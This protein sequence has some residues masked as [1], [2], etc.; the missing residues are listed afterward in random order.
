MVLVVKSFQ[1]YIGHGKTQCVK[2]MSWMKK[3]KRCARRWF[4]R[5]EH[6]TIRAFGPEQKT[7][8]TE[9]YESK[10]N[11]LRRKYKQLKSIHRA[12]LE[13]QLKKSQTEIMKLKAR[14]AELE[15]NVEREAYDSFPVRVA[16]EA[17]KTEGDT[18]TRAIRK[19]FII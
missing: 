13:E 16:V 9:D 2:H 14:V 1:I 10:Y 5:R 17:S 15:R 18:D 6:A 19:V 7:E 3:R 4:T 8:E 12:T 11:A